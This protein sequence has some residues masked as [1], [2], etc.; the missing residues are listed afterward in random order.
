MLEYMGVIIPAVLAPSL[1]AIGRELSLLGGL[2]DTVQIDVVDA[3]RHGTLTWPYTE[4]S[5]ALEEFRAKGGTLTDWGNFTYEI[6]LMVANQA[7]VAGTWISLGAQRVMLHEESVPDLHE[8]IASFKKAYGHDATFAPELLSLGL[9]LH[10]DTD[11]SRVDPHVS[12]IDYV[13]F[14]GI[15]REGKQGEP[16]HEPVLDAIRAFHKRH[17]DT[18]IQVD[19]GVTLDTAPYLLDA[20]AHRLVVGS[21][22]KRGDTRAAYQSFIEIAER[23]GRYN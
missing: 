16:F 17:P 4:S 2:A 18:V 9:A 23:Y 15:R 7:Q 19:G 3:S 20:G 13:Q 14:M 8:A 10:A 12:E 22:L 1:E 11:F 5:S 21:A 6:D